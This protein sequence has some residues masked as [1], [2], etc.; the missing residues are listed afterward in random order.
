MGGLLG[1]YLKDLSKK[2]N[3]GS[4]DIGSWDFGSPMGTHGAKKFFC[5]KVHILCGYPWCS[6][7]GTFPTF[8]PMGTCFLGPMT[9]HLPPLWQGILEQCISYQVL[10]QVDKLSINQSFILEYLLVLR[11][12]W[13]INHSLSKW[14]VYQKRKNCKFLTTM[15]AA[16]WFSFYSASSWMFIKNVK[17]ANS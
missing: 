11:L 2:N 12:L 1:P 5:L 6:L 13:I 10:T 14:M 8:V 7:F 16:R 17:I 9:S 3:F 15:L 4:R